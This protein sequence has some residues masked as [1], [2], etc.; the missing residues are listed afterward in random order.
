MCYGDM[1]KGT[2]KC[3]CIGSAPL[4]IKNRGQRRQAILTSGAHTAWRLGVIQGSD[5]HRFK[6]RVKWEGHSLTMPTQILDTNLCRTRDCC[7]TFLIVPRMPDT[8]RT[9]AP[10]NLATSSW[11]VNM[12]VM[13]AVWR[14]ILKGVPTSFSFLTTFGAA[15]NPSTTPV[16]LIRH[17]C[18]DKLIY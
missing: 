4:S 15:S 6:H 5:A 9:E 16:A 11:L 10:S 17:P 3:L 14:A 1:A 12:P 8:V 18:A 7:G 2:V 13:K